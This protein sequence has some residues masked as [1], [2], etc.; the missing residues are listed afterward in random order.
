MN[1]EIREAIKQLAKSPGTGAVPFV[2]AR[3]KQVDW[4]KRLCKCEDEDGVE[5]FD[6]RLRAVADEEK[7]GFCLKPKVDSYVLLGPVNN[8]SSSRFV[9]MYTEID[10]LEII[11]DDEVLIADVKEGK[12]TFNKGQ[13]DGMVKV[14]P[15]K[16]KLNNLENK[17]NDILVALKGVT[18][19]IPVGGGGSYAMASNFASIQSLQTTQKSDL[20]NTDITH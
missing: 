4:D 12:F 11:A 1:E 17:V 9:A 5:F 14:G 19:P 18:I 2:T 10:A 16:D 20:E 6:V 7:K 13:N 8:F 15:L 3:V